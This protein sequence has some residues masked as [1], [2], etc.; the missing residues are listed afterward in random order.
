MFAFAASEV[1]RGERVAWVTLGIALHLDGALSTVWP[2]W[3]T[4][5]D[6]LLAR[7]WAKRLRWVRRWDEPVWRSWD[8]VTPALTRAQLA[9]H[10]AARPFWRLEAADATSFAT[11]SIAFQ[12]VPGAHNAAFERASWVLVRVPMDTA[13]GELLVTTRMLCETLPVQ[14]AVAGYLCHVDACARG[15]G[16]DQ[17]WAWARRY[18]GIHVVDPVA[19]SWDAPRGIWGTNWLTFVGARWLEVDAVRIRV[20]APSPSI[21]IISTRHGTLLCAGAAPSI[22]DQNH[23]EDLSSYMLVSRRV[24]PMLIADPTSL[25]GMFADRDC[26]SAWIHRFDD[27]VGWRD[28]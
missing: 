24:A 1:S 17:A 26:T 22:G 9:Q 25:P 20:E 10:G 16:F 7:P 18:Y 14:Q 21:Q 8:D 15:V 6:A 19:T 27:P 11:T 4:A 3:L 5:W 2:A 12:N 13:P 23:F 28:V